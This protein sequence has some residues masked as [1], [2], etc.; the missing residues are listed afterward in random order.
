M[1]RISFSSHP[2]T[3]IKILVKT[4][5]EDTAFYTDHIF[6]VVDVG[7]IW[8]YSF[9]EWWISFENQPLKSSRRSLPWISCHELQKNQWEI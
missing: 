8:L 4:N 3:V 5:K 7:Y 2:E 9:I 6:W 1:K